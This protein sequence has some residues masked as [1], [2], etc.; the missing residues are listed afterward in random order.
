ML[1][2]FTSVKQA[3]LRPQVVY[4]I[5][6]WAKCLIDINE[7]KIYIPLTPNILFF[8]SLSFSLTC[9]YAFL[10]H[11]S[12]FLFLFFL[13]LCFT[14]ICY[15][16]PQTYKHRTKNINYLPSTCKSYKTFFV[17]KYSSLF[18][19]RVQKK[20]IDILGCKS[21]E[22]TNALVFFFATLH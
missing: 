11:I 6:H 2:I 22:V 21:M 12:L 5:A 8:L 15:F 3:N 20:H 18:R 13:P 4:N 17:G 19:H 7:Y 9:S 14:S 1:Q 16:F 10:F